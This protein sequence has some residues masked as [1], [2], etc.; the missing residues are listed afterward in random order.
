T[1]MAEDAQGLIVAVGDKLFCIRNGKMTPYAYKGGAEPAYFWILNL[2][3]AHDGAIW[4]ASHNGIFRLEDGVV[5][6][7]STAEGL[8]SNNGSCIFE[9]ADGAVWAG[10]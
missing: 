3:V 6:R 9:D 10:L 1:G 7:W 2:C 5:R 4:L 8:S